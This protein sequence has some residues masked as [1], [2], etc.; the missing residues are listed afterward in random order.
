MVHL[1]GIRIKNL[2][3][4]MLCTHFAWPA[5]SQTNISASCWSLIGP[6]ATHLLVSR[7]IS[8]RRDMRLNQLNK[9]QKQALRTFAHHFMN[10]YYRNYVYK[11]PRSRFRHI[12]YTAIW[13]CAN[14]NIRFNLEKVTYNPFKEYKESLYYVFYED[15]RRYTQKKYHNAPVSFTFVRNPIERFI[16]GLAES[17]YRSVAQPGTIPFGNKHATKNLLHQLFDEFTIGNLRNGSITFPEHL[18][19]MSNILMNIIPSFI[20]RIEEFEIGWKQVESLYRVKL[21]HDRNLG[22]HVSSRDPNS[23]RALLKEMFETN[24]EYLRAL[25]RIYLADFVCFNYQ[26]PEV[27]KSL[28]IA[29]KYSIIA[30]T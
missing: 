5:A 28:P 19:P 18:Y 30:S 2:L 25:C 10:F 14:D 6:E 27:C 4:F 12:V 13:K 23:V 29:K 26:L 16:A 24:P 3:I 7:F 20:G 11:E 15:L 22:Y 1:L 9:P 21:P 8:A 17:Y